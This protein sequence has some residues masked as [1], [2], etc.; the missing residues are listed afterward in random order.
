MP[1]DAQEI[2]HRLQCGK[3]AIL[4]SLAPN[5]QTEYEELQTAIHHVKRVINAA[6]SANGA[7]SQDVLAHV[8]EDEGACR[9]EADIASPPS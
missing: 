7:I 1:V 4:V 2:L 6:S 8:T 3:Q 9:L 5:L